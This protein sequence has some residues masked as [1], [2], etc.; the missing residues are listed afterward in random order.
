MAVSHPCTAACYWL[1]DPGYS[2]LL[3]KM[4]NL[5]LTLDVPQEQTS[6]IKSALPWHWQQLH[7]LLF[8]FCSSVALYLLGTQTHFTQCQMARHNDT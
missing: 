6:Q 7:F 8:I 4:K 5:T 3:M 2:A 1:S